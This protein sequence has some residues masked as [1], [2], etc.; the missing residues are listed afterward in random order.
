MLCK[1]DFLSIRRALLTNV[2]ASTATIIR[3]PYVSS[4][5]N[6]ADFLYATTDVAIWSCCETG[7]GIAASS[8]ATLRP[9]FRTFFSRSKL[10]GGTTSRQGSSGWPSAAGPS[11]GYIR[12]GSKG[13]IETFG[14]RSDIGKTRGVTTI[15]ESDGSKD[16]DLERGSPEKG[17]PGEGGSERR[18]RLESEWS[19]SESKLALDRSSGED[20]SWTGIRKTTVSKQVVH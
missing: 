6:Q 1:I 18:L 9:L 2:S 4:L 19:N 7:I 11:G 10:F 14:L 3:I 20:E 16:M 5:A 13:G 17:G 8:I 12:S 15:I